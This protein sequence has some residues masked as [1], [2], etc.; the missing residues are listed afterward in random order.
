MF[1]RACEGGFWGLLRLEKGGGVVVTE[2]GLRV[3]CRGSS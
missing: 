2:G 1:Y 3:G